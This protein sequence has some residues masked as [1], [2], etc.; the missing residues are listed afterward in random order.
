MYQNQESKLVAIYKDAKSRAE[1]HLT[2]LGN[3]QQDEIVESDRILQYLQ[4]TIDC[5][6]ICIEAL[7]E[8]SEIKMQYAK[9]K[10]ELG[11]LGEEIIK[12]TK[13]NR[14]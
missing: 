12:L 6:K 4:E 9:Y 10:D 2:L 11:D 13:P 5:L 1:K 3:A 8:K 14:W 7:G